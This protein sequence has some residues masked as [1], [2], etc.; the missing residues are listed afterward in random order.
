MTFTPYAVD[1]ELDLVLERDVDV[2][3]ELVW[4]AWTEPEL[5]LQWFTPKPWETAV[6]EVDL[7]P[8]G[9]FRTVMRGPDG[10]ENDNVGCYL[11]VVPGEKLSWTSALGPD[12]RPAAGIGMPG[13]GDLHLTAIIE[14][15]PDGS[16]GTS[17][18]AIAL[19][20]DGATRRRHEEMGFHE[21]WGAVLDQLVELMTPA[22]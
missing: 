18:R 15:R 13:P 16:G 20:A 9:R 12:F 14:L 19:H 1:P 11:E 7:R 2:P 3:P 10:E 17:Y 4:R 22:A 6:C 8:G 5:M 21:G